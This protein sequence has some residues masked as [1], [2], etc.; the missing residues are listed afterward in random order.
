M[1][2]KYIVSLRD[3]RAVVEAVSK[4]DATR[5][6]QQQFPESFVRV[7]GLMNGTGL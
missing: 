5:R 4:A 2:L 7:L 1:T 6:G 3:G